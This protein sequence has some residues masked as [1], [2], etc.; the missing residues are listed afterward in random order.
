MALSEAKLLSLTIIFA[1]PQA[2]PFLLTDRA[3]KILYS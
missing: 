1:S 3:L 2:R